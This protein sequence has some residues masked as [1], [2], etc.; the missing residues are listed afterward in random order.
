MAANTTPKFWFELDGRQYG[1]RFM[2]IGEQVQAQVEIERLTN[3]KFSEW[4]KSTDPTQSTAA[5]MT[6]LAV[7]LNKVIVVWPNDVQ[8]YDLLE[9]DDFDVV[10]RMWEAYGE[11]AETFRKRRGA[12]AVSPAVGEAVSAPSL[13]P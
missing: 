5:F 10:A 2:T 13:V 6:Q 8:P 7:Y 11:A 4:A 9:S 3:G 12:P 1:A